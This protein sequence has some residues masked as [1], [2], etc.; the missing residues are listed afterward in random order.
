MA[1]EIY[2]KK[3][4]NNGSGSFSNTINLSAG[5][6]QSFQASRDPDMVAQGSKVAVTWAAYPDRNA[7]RP[8]EILVRESLNSGMVLLT[9]E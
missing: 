8:G 1:G 7:V 5:T 2:F 3:S 4:T 6:G 9:S